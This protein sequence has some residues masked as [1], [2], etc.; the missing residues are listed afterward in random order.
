MPFYMKSTAVSLSRVGLGTDNIVY[1]SH[2]NS[3]HI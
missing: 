1:F 3:M 2:M